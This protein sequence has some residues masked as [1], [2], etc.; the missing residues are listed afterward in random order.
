[1]KKLLQILLIPVFFAAVSIPASVASAQSASNC[2]DASISNTGPSSTNKIICSDDTKVVIKCTNGT[3]INV[4]LD[5][6]A[7]SGDGTVD[8]NTNG[9]NAGTGDA[10]NEANL[11][12]DVDN[13]CKVACGTCAVTPTTTTPT[14]PT[15]PV[16]IAEAKPVQ[17]PKKTASL[18]DTGEMTPL[19][20]AGIVSGSVVALLSATKFGTMLYRKYSAN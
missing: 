11:N 7:D 18:P 16:A 4:D 6:D 1:M 13:A 12:V 2:D 9:G 5:Q 20:L 3:V 10:N 19:M 17:P 15:T 8:G 14:N